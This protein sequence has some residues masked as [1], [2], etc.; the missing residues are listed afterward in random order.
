MVAL[1]M[2]ASGVDTLGVG[3]SFSILGVGCISFGGLNGLSKVTLFFWR[4]WRCFISDGG[5]EN[6][7]N[8]YLYVMTQHLLIL[9]GMYGFKFPKLFLE[10]SSR[11]LT[12]LSILII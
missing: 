2:V 1:V 8:G 11:D 7:H 4:W 5:C 3:L 6:I 10:I 9:K 12:L